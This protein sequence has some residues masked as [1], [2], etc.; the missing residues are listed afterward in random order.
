MYINKDFHKYITAA[1]IGIVVA[2]CIGLSYLFSNVLARTLESSE[3]ILF[4]GIIVFII[5]LSLMSL[6]FVGLSPKVASR[7]PVEE[8]HA[9]LKQFK[10]RGI[11]HHPGDEADGIVV[12]FERMMNDLYKSL[13]SIQIKAQGIDKKMEMLTKEM[14]QVLADQT[15]MFSLITAIESVRA[16]QDGF[17]VVFSEILSLVKR[18]GYLTSDVRDMANQLQVGANEVVAELERTLRQFAFSDPIQK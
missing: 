12:V 17:S 18:T 14:H 4:A 5:V 13:Q 6:G 9:L 11:T 7:K 1:L 3:S 16:Q 10:D 8:I 15:N 2:A